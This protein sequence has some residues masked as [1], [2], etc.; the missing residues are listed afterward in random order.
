MINPSELH[1]GASQLCARCWT[2]FTLPSVVLTSCVKPSRA[3]PG[4]GHCARGACV[5]CVCRVCVVCVSCVVCVCRVL[6][7][8]CVCVAKRSGRS[9]ANEL[10]PK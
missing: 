9:T 1:T 7:V 6:C 10:L 3:L 5:S 2:A 4:P 8:L